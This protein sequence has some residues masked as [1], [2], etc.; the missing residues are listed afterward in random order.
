MRL[1]GR[2]S[3]LFWGRV[4]HICKIITHFLGSS[5]N[6][7]HMPVLATLFRLRCHYVTLSAM[8]SQITSLTIVYASVYSVFRRW[9]KKTSKL[10]VTG[11]CA[12]NSPVTG[13][14]P[15]QMASKAENGSIWWRHDSAISILR[16]IMHGVCVVFTWRDVTPPPPPPRQ[17]HDDSWMTSGWKSYVR[18]FQTDFSVFLGISCRIALIWMP[19]GASLMISQHWFR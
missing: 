13:E 14:F 18:N 12:G 7:K 5:A 16:I 8:A 4:V 9:S 2:L 19:L 6:H 11:L 10:H 3:Q 17:E 1:C 15:A